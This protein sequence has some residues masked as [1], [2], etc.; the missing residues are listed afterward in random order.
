MT[1]MVYFAGG[2]GLGEVPQ[3]RTPSRAAAQRRAKR[4]A[5]DIG[6]CLGGGGGEGWVTA[7]AAAI[8]GARSERRSRGFC[9][10]PPRPRSRPV[11]LIADDDRL[12]HDADQFQARVVGEH[13]I[14]PRVPFVLARAEVTAEDG[15]G[16]GDVERQD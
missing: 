12:R 2:P 4:S 11:R 16:D 8:Q 10:L 14:E 1:A 5:R 3:P 6:G 7:R 13:V 9:P 15:T